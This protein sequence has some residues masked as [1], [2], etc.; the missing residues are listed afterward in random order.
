MSGSELNGLPSLIDQE[1]AKAIQEVA[2]T[3]NTALE[4]VKSGCSYVAE[5]LGTTPHDAVGLFLADPLHHLRFRAAE[6]YARREAEISARRG[7]KDKQPVCAT[8]FVPW[9]EAATKET[10]DELR[11]MWARLLAA[12]RDPKRSHQVRQSF[13]DAVKRMD[14][15]DA[16]IL[17]KKLDGQNY[18]PHA[19]QAFS[20]M[21]KVSEDQVEVSFMRLDELGLA[22]RVTGNVDVHTTATG[23]ELALAVH[24]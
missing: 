15:L 7:V 23:R 11:D 16:L 6:W 3:S 12:A 5:V 1:T 8:I 14:P 2:K 24:G 17:E 19:R 9:F 22:A 21:F 4:V 10:R 18:S 13:I 20:Q